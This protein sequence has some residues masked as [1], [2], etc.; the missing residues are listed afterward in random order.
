MYGRHLIQA[1]QSLLP[2][3]C[4]PATYSTEKELIHMYML[5]QLNV[6]FQSQVW[7]S[8]LIWGFF[9][10]LNIKNPDYGGHRKSIEFLK[11]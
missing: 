4:V 8:Q 5:Q 6:G 3:Y 9:Q 2:T 10:G 11:I 7:I 1:S